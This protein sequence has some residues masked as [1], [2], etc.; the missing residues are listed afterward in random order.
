MELDTD[1]TDRA[2]LAILSLTL[3]DSSRVWKGIDRE[4]TD[5]LFEKRLI[6][7]PTGKSKSLVLTDEGLAAAQETLK[8]FFRKT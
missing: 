4:I 6:Q 5:R 1:K 2:S 8:A 3:H 7:D